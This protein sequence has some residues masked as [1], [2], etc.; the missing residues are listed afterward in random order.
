MSDDILCPLPFVHSFF[1]VRGLYSACCNG[2]FDENSKHVSEMSA[3]EWFYSEQMQQLRKDMLDGNR[4]KMCDHCWR[5]DDLGIPSP[6]FGHKGFWI[7][8]DV[9]YENPKPQ[10]FDLKPSNHCNLACIF[11]TASS[12]DK[13]LKITESL[14]Q[15]DRPR[16]WDSSVEYVKKREQRLGSTFDP[17][18]IQYILEN[19]QDIKLLK[20]TGGEPFLSKDVLKILSMVVEKNPSI[21]IK[22]TTNGTVITK[23]FY[24]LLEKLEK[25]QIKFSID[26]VDQ[27]YTFIR[28]PSKWSQFQKRIQNN[29]EKLPNVK[30]NVNCL[31]TNMNLEQIPKI[32]NWFKQLQSQYSNLDYIIFDPNLTPDDNE[33]SL[34]MSPEKFLLDVKHKL[35]QQ[36]ADWDMQEN[37]DQ[38][39]LNVYK[40]IDDAIQNNYFCKEN[41][42]IFVQQEF[43]KQ[44][45]IRN[46]D[47]RQV[48]EPI[49]QEFFIDLFAGKYK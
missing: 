25:T 10:F 20:F 41:H 33:S 26:A 48:V 9:D 21:E 7:W 38:Q 16:R 32:R 40:K 18:V 1:D 4:N 29:M 11:C 17:Q 39:I 30:F 3:E 44:S 49:T 35:Q 2:S 42:A 24:P 5:K 28:F 12:S 14:D 47:I 36:T 46:L 13:I 8:H 19:I 15:K 34:Y 45:A 31:I 22:I 6:R 43:E 27:L 37:T 23:Q